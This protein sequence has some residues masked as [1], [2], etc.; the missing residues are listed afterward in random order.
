V[1][2][3][4]AAGSKLSMT[5]ADAGVARDFHD[6]TAHS[7]HSVRSSGHYLDWDTKPFLFKIYPDLPVVALP[8]T[9]DPLAVDALAAIGGDAAPRPGPV[10]LEGLTAVLFFSAGLTRKKTYPGGDEI[11]FRAAP[12]TGALY[13]TEVYVVAGAVEGLAAGVYHFSP[14]DFCLRRLRDGDH[15]ATLAAAAAEPDL[16]RRP[17]TL[18][19]S[20]IYW[21]NTWKYQARGYRH[22]FWD[23]GTMLANLLAA[24][25]AL[26]LDPQILAGFVDADVNALLGLDVMREAALELIALGAAGPIDSGLASQRARSAFAPSRNQRLGSPP[27]APRTAADAA[28]LEHQRPPAVPP[29]GYPT[30]PLSSEEVDYPSLREVHAASGLDTPS[31]VTAWRRAEALPARAPA[32][33]PIAL[34]P[35]RREA[36]RALGE[37]I[38][39]RASTR[40]FS[41]EPLGVLQLSTALAA[42]AARLPADFPAGLVT[43]YLIVNAVDGL[44]PGSYRYERGPHG[45]EP[46]SRGDYRRQSAYLCLEQ[47]LGGDA[48]AAIY[49]LAPLDAILARWGNRGYRLANLEA[50]IAGGRAYLAA[51]AQGFGASG[52]TFYDRDVVRFFEPS[53]RG[54]DAIFVTVLG[55]SVRGAPPAPLILGYDEA[56]IV[57]TPES[58]VV[59]SPR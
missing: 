53:A 9:F 32:T 38:R 10:T 46:L 47:A 52:L 45:L 31:A 49:F 58:E 27:A 43:P 56:L 36:G 25:G 13:Q 8:K 39:R 11:H 29:I 17:V 3:L 22:F 4:S 44:D 50:G 48:A 12:S 37:T 26:G 34:P 40:Q 42:A 7:Q 24:A 6:R 15:R 55:R 35:P 54:L 51:Y 16:A 18:A 23:S 5:N 57:T 20:A 28:Q 19:L 59:E 30:V 33:P 14:G 41:H 1:L 21:R 2:V